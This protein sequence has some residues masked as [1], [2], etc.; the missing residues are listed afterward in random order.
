MKRI[1]M[2][3]LAVSAVCAVSL[4]LGGHHRADAKA[5]TLIVQWEYAVYDIDALKKVGKGSAPLSDA[6]NSR[7]LK[8]WELVAVDADTCYFKRPMATP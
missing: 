1:A 6:L 2:I 4:W 3:P 5:P 7:G 8:G